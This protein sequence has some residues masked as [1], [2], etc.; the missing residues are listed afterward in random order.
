MF[1]IAPPQTFLASNKN[2][3]LDFTS[4]AIA[5]REIIPGSGDLFG[6]V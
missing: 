3:E 2:I 4:F 5:S 6:H 1:Y